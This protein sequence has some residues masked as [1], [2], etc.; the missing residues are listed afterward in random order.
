MYDQ[1]QKAMGL[2]TSDE[3]QR[4][5]IMKQVGAGAGAE[6]HRSSLQPSAQPSAPGAP[7]G[8]RA[9]VDV[10]VLGCRLARATL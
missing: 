6:R 8:R 10:N 9:G 3:Q 7:A 4:Q 1:R 5:D 2:P